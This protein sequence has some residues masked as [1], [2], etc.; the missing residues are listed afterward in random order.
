[1]LLHP[2][3]F[4]LLCKIPVSVLKRLLRFLKRLPGNQEVFPGLSEYLFGNGEGL[5]RITELQ[6]GI[7]DLIVDGPIVR[8]ILLRLLV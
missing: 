5:A 3:A 6:A 4:S 8:E 7:F 2:L 1:L